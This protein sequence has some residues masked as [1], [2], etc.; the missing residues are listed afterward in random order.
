MGCLGVS[1]GVLRGYLAHG[2]SVQLACLVL[3]CRYAVRLSHRP[4]LGDLRP[5]FEFDIRNTLPGV[6]HD[7]CSLWNELVQETRKRQS[8]IHNGCLWRS[9]IDDDHLYSIAIKIHPIYVLPPR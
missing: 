2:D 8:H 9:Y 4:Y 6:Q 5:L 3:F 7:F 1:E